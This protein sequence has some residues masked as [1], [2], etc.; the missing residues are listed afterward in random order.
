M[1]RGAIVTKY[2]VAP[3]KMPCLLAGGFSGRT[4]WA[5]AVPT[6]TGGSR[7]VVRVRLTRKQTFGVTDWHPTAQKP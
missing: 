1:D 6:L 7:S 5:L 3:S 4:G 2:T